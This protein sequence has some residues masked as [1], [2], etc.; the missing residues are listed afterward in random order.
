M[1]HWLGQAVHRVR[2]LRS[3]DL[4]R[5]GVALRLVLHMPVS[6]TVMYTFLTEVATLLHFHIHG[7]LERTSNSS[8]LRT[9]QPATYFL[10]LAPRATTGA[11]R[12]R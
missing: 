2:V 7:K 5:G 3:A 9:W 8:T 1:A 4:P 11:E 12:T 6:E 10:L